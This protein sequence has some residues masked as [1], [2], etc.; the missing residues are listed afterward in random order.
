MTK[1]SDNAFPSIL[2]TEGTEPSAPAAGKQRLYIDSTTHKLKRTDSSGTDVTIESSGAVATDTIW[3][4]AGD[5]AVGSGADTAAKLS[6][7]AVGA[8][9]SRINGAVAWNSGTSFPGSKATGDRYYRSDLLME[10]I[11]NGTAWVS[12]TLHAAPMQTQVDMP[13]VATMTSYRLAMPPLAGNSDIWL[14]RIT[15]AFLVNG[16]TALSGSHKW[17]ASVFKSD[18]AGGTSSLGTFTIDSGASSVWR[19]AT[20]ITVGAAATASTYLGTIETS[21][22]K[23][24]TPGGLFHSPYV[25][26]R[27]IAT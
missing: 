13:I 15:L 5:L 17:V 23:T 20:D 24:G 21:W 8:A 1:A 2:I 26:Y 7:G 4:A 22:T 6:I 12:S 14:D 27:Y 18:N 25:V 9:L 19:L 3:D 11:W 10:Y 16:G